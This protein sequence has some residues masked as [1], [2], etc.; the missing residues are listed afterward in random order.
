MDL[1]TGLPS[2]DNFTVLLVVLDI[3]TGFCIV[4]P[5]HSESASCVGQALFDLFSLL[6]A[7]K[8]LQSDQGSEFDNGVMKVMSTQFD[9]KLSFS[10]SHHH[11]K[12]SQI[13]AQL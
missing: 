4:K 8:T 10:P 13:A 9:M 3:F 7:H 5:L 1:I 11:T 6:G 12:Y 2:S